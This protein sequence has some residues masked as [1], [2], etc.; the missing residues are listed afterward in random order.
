MLTSLLSL[1]LFI[2]SAAPAVDPAD[3]TPSTVAP[4]PSTVA[5]TPSTVAP[6][7]STIAPSAAAPATATEPTTSALPQTSAAPPKMDPAWFASVDRGLGVSVGDSFSAELHFFTQL[8]LEQVIS[9]DTRSPEFRVVM[10]RPVLRG[11]LIRPWIS[12]F[13][14]PELAGKSPALLDAELTIFPHAAFG[15]KV[16][17]FLT[18][19]SREF[20]VPPFRL[21]FPDFAPSNIYFRDNRD[22]GLMLFGM[23]LDGHLEYYAGVFN[24]NGINQTPGG[25][26]I[27]G[28]ARLAANLRGKPV[29]TETPELDDTAT[30]LAFGLNATYGRHDLPLP[31]GSPAAAVAEIAPYATLG[32]DLTVH[33]GACS[34]QAEGYAKW[35]QLSGDVTQWSAGG[36]L[37]G[38]CFVYRRALQL[39]ARADVIDANLDTHAG[40]RA[41]AEGLLVYYVQGNHLKF[42]L[43]Y[44]YGN[45]RGPDILTDA[46]TTHTLTLQGQLQL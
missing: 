34:A 17:Q 11:K 44:A 20:L 37:H 36:Y 35:Q 42:Q 40:L 25:A 45:V 19:F 13:V 21:L 23:P 16:G 3:P 22:L 41:Q 4:T 15:I 2:Q 8:R 10:A 18:P 14:Q 43:R 9:D 39:A 1:T 27:M 29:Y 31:A 30:Q 24:G 32:I 7:P 12:Y 26:R 28:I 46:S 38:G 5:P 33:K 6:T